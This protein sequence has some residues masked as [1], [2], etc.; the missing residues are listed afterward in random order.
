MTR[1]GVGISRR[2]GVDEI[3]AT[4]RRDATMRFSTG[5]RRFFDNMSCD[6]Q[7]PEDFWRIHLIENA[8]N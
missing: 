1:I 4:E 6:T 3:L 7:L 2:R 5:T 8:A